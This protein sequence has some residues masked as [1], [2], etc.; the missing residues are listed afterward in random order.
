MHITRDAKDVH[1]FTCPSSEK[2][3][4]RG[5]QCAEWNDRI[6]TAS[7]VENGGERVYSVHRGHGRKTKSVKLTIFQ[8]Y[9]RDVDQNG[10]VTVRVRLTNRKEVRTMTETETEA[11]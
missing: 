4:S 10:F 9:V 5:P 1:T 3:E 2:S 8:L 6:A 11:N 7:L